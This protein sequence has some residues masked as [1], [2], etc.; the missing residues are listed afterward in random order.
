LHKSKNC[1]TYRQ[2]IK[3]NVNLSINF[4]EHEDI[5]L[6]TNDLLNLLQHAAKEAT[7]NNNPQ[8]T[9][10]NIHILRN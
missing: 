10:N 4:K 5:A 6:E 7:T 2:I 3:D 9:T 8:R 1:D